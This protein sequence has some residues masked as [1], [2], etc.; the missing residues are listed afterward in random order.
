M[1]ASAFSRLPSLYQGSLFPFPPKSM[2]ISNKAAVSSP[3]SPC[4]TLIEQL[5]RNNHGDERELDV[6]SQYA[7][8]F[9]GGQM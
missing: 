5:C 7:P 9:P 4:S 2:A 1:S 6:G 3:L 8:Y